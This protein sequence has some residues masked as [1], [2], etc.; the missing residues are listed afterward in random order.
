MRRTQPSPEQLKQNH[1][2]LSLRASVKKVQWRQTLSYE[3]ENSSSSCRIRVTTWIHVREPEV[4][5]LRTR[6]ARSIQYSLVFFSPWAPCKKITTLICLYTNAIRSISVLLRDKNSSLQSHQ[7]TSSFSGKWATLFISSRASVVWHFSA[8]VVLICWQAVAEEKWK[9]E[10]CSLGI[11]VDLVKL[12]RLST[13]TDYPNHTQLW[14]HYR[15]LLNNPTC[16]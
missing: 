2:S 1:G 11:W 16:E 3:A 8:V 13:R 6:I 14:S 4:S 9:L 7:T 12:L 5:A 10:T 15:K